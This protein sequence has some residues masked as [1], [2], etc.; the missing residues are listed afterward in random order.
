MRKRLKNPA[1]PACRSAS[2]ALNLPATA[3]Y[4]LKYLLRERKVWAAISREYAQQ[5]GNAMTLAYAQAL[6]ALPPFY[7]I[8][9]VAR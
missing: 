5:A 3:R 4:P 8:A 1:M 6:P 7:K 2:A 9:I